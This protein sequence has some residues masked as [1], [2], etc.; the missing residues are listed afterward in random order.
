MPVPNRLAGLLGIA[1]PVK[2]TLAG[3]LSGDPI[4]DVAQYDPGYTYGNLLPFKKNDQTRQVS[5]AAPAMVKDLAQA[6]RAP[7][8]AY[9]GEIDTSGPQGVVQAN[10]IALG[11]LGANLPADIPAGSLGMIK[12]NGMLGKSGLPTE[13]SKQVVRPVINTVPPNP[14][15]DA[16]GYVIDSPS[17]ALKINAMRDGNFVASYQPPWLKGGKGFFATGDDPVELAQYGLN[18]IKNSE[19]GI[20]ASNTARFNKSLLGQL[21][22][23][24]FNAD[25][26]SQAQ[27]TQSK[28][29]YLTHGPSGV[30]IRISD[31]DLPLHYEQPDVDLRSWMSDEEKIKAIKAAIE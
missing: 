7:L 17:M 20:N 28:S 18:K 14:L 16:S 27:S 30:K 31:H 12:S 23:L 11:L 2:N 8:Q 13:I 21:Q 6:L 5:W 24:G 1:D 15:W 29:S 9:R 3:L 4:A 22:K 25:D 26:F 10:N 19:R